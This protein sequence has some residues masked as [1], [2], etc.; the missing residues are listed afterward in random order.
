MAGGDI[1]GLKIDRSSGSSS[2]LGRWGMGVVLMLL[3]GLGVFLWNQTSGGI[4]VKTVRA[5]SPGAVSDAATVLNATGYVTARRRATISSKVTGKITEILVEEGMSVGK[6]QLVARLDRVNVAAVLELAEAQL[7]ASKAATNETE[8]LLNEAELEFARVARLAA[9]AIASQADLDRAEA[10]V[11]SLKAR[12]QRL[13]SEVRV[14]ERQVAMRQQDLEDLDIRAP[15]SGVVISKDA[16][17]GEVISPVS[18]GSGFTRTGICTLVDMDSL[19]IE[20]DVNESYINRVRAGQPIVAVLDAYK[21]WKIKASVIAIVPSADRQKATVRVRIRFLAPDPRILPEM[22]VKVSFQSEA[23]AAA[24]GAR[25]GR[26][27][28]DQAC[29]YQEAG[30]DYLWVISANKAEKRAV[31]IAGRREDKVLVEAGVREGEL[32]VIDPP[33]ELENGSA[34]VVEAS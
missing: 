23:R 34:V 2:A 22:G 18:A 28:V 7:A 10:R 17:P 13:E 11:D 9:E 25:E 30:R 4:L 3:I 6:D 20:V 24:D 12:L 16:Q 21:D 5:A 8:V 14:A 31:K 29:V 32:I 1:H 33:D 15:F 27:E 19:E 26:I